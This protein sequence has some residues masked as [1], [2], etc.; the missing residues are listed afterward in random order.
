MSLTYKQIWEQYS[1][2]EFVRRIYVKR[3][4]ENGSYESSFTEIP[5]N[6]VRDSSVGSLRRT[7]PNSSWDF[8][9]V[10]VNNARLNILSAYQE[11]ASEEDANSIFAGFLRHNS[12]VRIVDA[13]ID[14]YTDP[15]SPEEISV[16]TFEGLIDARTAT[17]EQGYESLTVLDYISI[18][19]TINVQELSLSSTT[20]NTLVYEVMNRSPFTKYFNIDNSTTYINA[21]YNASSIDVSVYEG[22]VLQM[23]EDLAKGHSIFYINPSDNYFYF[24]EVEPTASVQYEFLERNDRK[25]DIGSYR[26]GIDRQVTH[27]YWSDTNISSVPLGNPINPIPKNFSI[28]G[29]TNNTQRQNLLDFVRSKTEVPKPYFKLELPYFPI[30][31]LLD[32]VVIQSFGQAPPD[33]IR[34]GMFAW[35]STETTNPSEAPRWRKPAGIRI[36]ADDE[37]IVRGITHD[38]SLKTTLEVERIP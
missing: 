30:I 9:K 2:Y 35:T 23:L 8:G 29:V 15:N 31:N 16:T 18:L 10:V 36:S 21:G 37:W 33:A 38:A 4:Q 6:I 13:V 17:T 26:Q 20:I 25:I 1:Q 11:F 7:L 32:R 14:K 5:Q 28:D 24:K 19:D 12:I 22:T 3:L 34:W 27:W